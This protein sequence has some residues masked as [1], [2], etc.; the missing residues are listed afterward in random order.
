MTGRLLSLY[1]GML[2]EC[3]RAVLPSLARQ[4]L[5]KTAILVHSRKTGLCSPLRW[6]SPE[7][8]HSDAKSGEMVAVY[9][10]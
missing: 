3:I 1:E 9:Q 8:S 2:D 5:V 4:D 10:S 7:Y 6:V